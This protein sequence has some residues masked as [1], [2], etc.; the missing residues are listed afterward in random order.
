[1]FDTKNSTAWPGKGEENPQE[2]IVF[3]HENWK[4]LWEWRLEESSVCLWKVLFVFNFE[5]ISLDISLYVSNVLLT[6]RKNYEFISLVLFLLDGEINHSVD[7][8]I[9]RSGYGKH[10]SVEGVVY[11]GNWQEDKMNGKGTDY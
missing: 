7:G 10:Q 11:E 5:V 8:V 9:M 1:M 3:T 4:F 6:N 2:I